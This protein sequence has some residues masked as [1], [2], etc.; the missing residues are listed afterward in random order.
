M[1]NKKSFFCLSIA[2]APPILG[3]AKVV[4]AEHNAKQ[5]ILFLLE[6]C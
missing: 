5:K 2:E 3:G 6:H 1:P 4:Q